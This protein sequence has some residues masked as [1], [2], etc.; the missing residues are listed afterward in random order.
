[1]PE[2][3]ATWASRF[4][5]RHRHGVSVLRCFLADGLKMLPWGSKRSACPGP[6]SAS[7]WRDRPLAWRLNPLIRASCRAECGSVGFARALVV[8]PNILLMDDRFGPGR[9]DCGTLR[10][11]PG[12]VGGRAQPSRALRFYQYRRAVLMCTGSG[13]RQQSGRILGNQG[14]P[15]QRVPGSELRTAERILRRA[16][17]VA[18]TAPGGKNGSR[19]GIGSQLPHLLELTAGRWR[20]R[21]RPMGKADLPRS[22]R[23][24]GDR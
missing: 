14:F 3:C 4:R 20:P 22:P 17:G 7:R 11:L 5:A 18:G 1:M 19:L 24:N 2:T 12:F 6:R 23:V 13:V 10:R 8:H 16:D 9:V 15:P 21:R